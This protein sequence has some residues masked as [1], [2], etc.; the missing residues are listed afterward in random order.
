MQINPYISKLDLSN[1]GLEKVPDEIL[2]FKNLKKLNLS[3]NKI[4]QLPQ[5]IKKLK[6]L[7]SIDLSNN[8]LTSIFSNICKLPKLKTLILNNNQ[9]KKIP[10]QINLLTDLKV[11]SI[12]NNKLTILPEEI[13]CLKNLE[14]LNISGNDFK[15]FPDSIL[16]LE[17]LK[18]IWINNN[19]FKHFPAKQLI[20]ELSNLKSIYCYS[21]SVSKYDE[22]D[23]I[24]KKLSEIKGNSILEL[25]KMNIKDSVPKK[26][27]SKKETQDSGKN[28]IFISYA[29]KDSEWLE[30]VLIFLKTMAY[31]G[32][33]LD[34]WSDQKIK[35][36]QNWKDEIDIALNESYIA[37]LLVS[38]NFLASDFI[39]N[40]E[41]PQILEN[42]DKKGTKILSLI[43]SPCRYVKNNNI[44]KFQAVNDP[45]NPLSNNTTH[46]QD[47]I[48][49]KL[50]YVIEEYIE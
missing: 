6:R 39:H 32:I 10:S 23:P 41:L 13:S 37:I 16:S 46:E 21:L 29:H 5:N 33:K 36:G 35:A 25:K 19:N 22:L 24:Y 47:E 48:L 27:P 2:G 40:N 28:K 49:L 34:I 30:R 14:L 15:Y 42:A 3:N 1:K 18:Q 31:E 7:E 26:S 43:L 9:I 11:L 50:T 4:R 12:A 38:S 44:S 17:K 45:K 8:Q 20:N